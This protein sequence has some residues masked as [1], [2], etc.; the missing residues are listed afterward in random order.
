MNTAL[1]FRGIHAEILADRTPEVDIE[2]SLNCGKTTLCLWM[3]LEAL[4]NFPGIWSFAF[5]YSDTDTKTK[6]R[7]AI[8]QLCAIRSE[9]MKWDGT[10]LCYHVPN[11][12]RL[13]TFGIKSADLLSR[14]SK[15]RGLPV[16]RIYNDQSE[17]LPEDMSG[18]LRGRLRPDLAT[19]LAGR[20]YPTRLTFS[21]NPLSD[22][23]WLAKQF[24]ATNT[25]KGRRYFSLSLYDNAHNLP[26]ETIAGLEAAY[27]PDHPRYK[28]IILGQRGPNILG[29][30]IYAGLF[31]RELHRREITVRDGQ[32]IEGFCTGK[33]HPCW[34]IAQRTR[35]GALQFLGGIIG[36]DL[37]LTDFLPIVLEHRRDWFGQGAD[38]KTCASPTGAVDDPARFSDMDLLRDY[39]FKP[40]W[41]ENSN[42]PDV[43]LAMIEQLGD[44]MRHRTHTGEEALAV[45]DDPQRWLEASREGIKPNPFLAEGFEVGY[46]KDEHFSSVA[47]KE[48]RQ[49]KADDWFEMGQRGAELLVQNF[50]AG[51]PTQA[52]KD[53]KA[54]DAR[55]SE[56]REPKERSSMD[57]SR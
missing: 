35:T 31:K 40:R 57:W 15:L 32:L 38:I 42:A 26:P 51:K 18:E 52:A 22:R 21:P 14:Y 33:S 30:P 50:C 28:S 7:P 1:T 4:R 43:R 56:P 29:T 3:E 49:P 27:P 19:R 45:N 41:C 53:A 2:G 10:E 16:S 48:V 5:R 11:G 39:G 44:A 25:L 12:S 6:L 37:F 34:V 9:S 8:E 20:S 23:S 24:P 55:A 47:H 54:R 36:V 46:V 13:Y 17:E